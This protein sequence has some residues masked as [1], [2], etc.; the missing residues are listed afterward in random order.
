MSR[1]TAFAAVSVLALLSLVSSTG[2]VSD[3]GPAVDIGILSYPIPVSPYFQDQLEDNF[4]ERERYRRV[5]ILGPLTA[6]GPTAAL[7]EP[8]DDEI[9][10]ALE[11]ARP[12]EGGLPLLHE[13]QRNNVRILRERIG[14][15]VDPPREYPLIGP[16]QLHHVH[17][18]CTV[19]FSETT[20]VGWPIPY[21]T[22]DEDCQEVVYI[23]HDHLHMVGHV[24]GGAASNY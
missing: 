21:T 23:D 15:Y 8:S 19:Y 5:P 18:K 3:I 6:G 22:V 10:R 14:D 20:R 4:H 2:C 1:K 11:A 24:T 13:V 9:M 7:D 17:Y 12:V 16:A